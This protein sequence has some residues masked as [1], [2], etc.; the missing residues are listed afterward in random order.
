M[1]RIIF[2]MHLFVNSFESIVIISTTMTLKEGGRRG[3][4]CYVITRLVY[5][6]GYGVLRF[7]IQIILLK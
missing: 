4:Q 7:V 1:P 3:R 2:L 5:D 6:K